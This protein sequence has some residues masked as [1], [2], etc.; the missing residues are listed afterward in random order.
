MTLLSQLTVRHGAA[1][2]LGDGV[3]FA[4]DKASIPAIFCI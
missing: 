1:Q 2:G 3:C 4:V